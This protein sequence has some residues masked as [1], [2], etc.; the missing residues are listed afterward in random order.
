MKEKEEK[1]AA[2]AAKAARKAEAAAR[3]SAKLAKK[4]EAAMIPASQLFRRMT[5]KYSMWDEAGLPTHDK[6]G[7]EISKKATKKNKK[8]YDAQV[9][10]NKE[11]GLPSQ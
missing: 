7:K 10:L 9:A 6:D 8:L 4:K 3:N 5:D 2:E 1:A 11:F